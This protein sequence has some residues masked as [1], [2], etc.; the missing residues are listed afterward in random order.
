MTWKD[1]L[2]NEEKKEYFKNLEKFLKEEY[3]NKVIYPKKEEIYRAFDLVSYEN[4]K[5]VIL[6]QDP[7]HNVGQANGLAFSVNENIELPAS[8]KNIYKEIENEY[9]YR[10][11][12]NGDLTNWAKQGVLLLNTVLTVEEHKPN[13]H[14]NKGWEQFTDAIIKYLSSREKPLIFVLWG[15]NA[16]SKKK[17]IATRHYVLE[18][19]HPSPLSCYRGFFGCNHFKKINEI[20]QYLHEKEINWY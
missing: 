13:S 6:G 11:Q 15:L 7:Y 14:K 16:R 5:V 17:Y 3:T 1:I 18:A 12:K 9:G 2:I 19:P 20:L 4:V 8:L 10:M